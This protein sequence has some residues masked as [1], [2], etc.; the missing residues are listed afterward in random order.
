MKKDLA[1]GYPLYKINPKSSR[2]RYLNNMYYA[3]PF[4]LP[5]WG[6]RIW[7][8][9][10]PTFANKYFMYTLFR[11]RANFLMT[12]TCVANIFSSAL[13]L[14][15]AGSSDDESSNTPI[16]SESNKRPRPSEVINDSSVPSAKLRRI[17]GPMP[18]EQRSSNLDNSSSPSN[19]SGIPENER[20][21]HS[22]KRS[23]E[24]RFFENLK[25]S[26]IGGPQP[27][28]N[29]L[30][31]SIKYDTRAF[32]DLPGAVQQELLSNLKVPSTV[33]G[34]IDKAHS[35]A[36]KEI[37]KKFKHF[38]LTDQVA[39]EDLRNQLAPYMYS[40][41]NG[42]LVSNLEAIDLSSFY[43]TSDDDIFWIANHFPKLKSLK[44]SSP[45][46]I[47]GRGLKYLKRLNHLKKIEFSKI[48]IKDKHYPGLGSLKKL[49]TL[50]LEESGMSKGRIIYLR[51]LKKL[52]ELEISHDSLKQV[53]IE[54][55]SRFFPN[56]NKLNIKYSGVQMSPAAVRHLKRLNH[57]RSLDISESYADQEAIDFLTQTFPDLETL[58]IDTARLDDS[59]IPILL[60]LRN[61]RHLSIRSTNISR[62][63]IAAIRA[64]LPNLR[65][66]KHNYN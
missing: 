3:S 14:A 63:G 42:H 64:G 12:F 22:I 21:W 19:T 47:S 20:V 58:I 27:F 35:Q 10:G 24:N 55:I 9:V 53:D 18:R 37:L 44:L 60:R 65:D 6:G 66:F 43:Q 56:L 8:H 54:R 45:N 57:L 25:A 36:Y 38:P 51:Q 16:S 48:R 33:Y 46:L 15:F 41:S 61:L 5:A 34:C 23:A 11:D 52:E 32:T 39:R 29:R 31:Q 2:H 26:V 62:A 17:A 7:Q 40:D 4:I 59:S 49:K 13:N 50:I 30:V 1:D 28:E